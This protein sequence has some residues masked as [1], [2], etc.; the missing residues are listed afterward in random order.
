MLAGLAVPH[1]VATLLAETQQILSIPSADGSMIPAG[2]R[3]EC[4]QSLV[5]T[6]LLQPDYLGRFGI[7]GGS[8]QFPGH[9]G[10]RQESTNFCPVAVYQVSA[11][12]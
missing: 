9:H 2:E 7:I 1:E 8:C 5:R 12:Y 10:T 3:A 4:G 6:G 11:A